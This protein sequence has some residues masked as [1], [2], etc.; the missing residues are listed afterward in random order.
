MTPEEDSE[1]SATQ[2]TSKLGN[3]LCGIGQMTSS[4]WRL[5]ASLSCTPTPTEG[6]QL[7]WRDPGSKGAG[8]S[9]SQGPT[10]LR[11]GRYG[12]TEL[13]SPWGRV[14]LS[15]GRGLFVLLKN[16]DKRVEI[17]A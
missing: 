6:T 3:C 13:S 2:V 11:S 14:S 17:M 12:Y 7:A 10:G 15:S 1:L 9:L 5:L 8:S 16:K 4:F